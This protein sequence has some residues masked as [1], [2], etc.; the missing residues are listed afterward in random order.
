MAS[1]GISFFATPE[2]MAKWVKQLASCGE[3]KFAGEF[4]PSARVKTTALKPHYDRVAAEELSPSEFWPD[5][6]NISVDDGRPITKEQAKAPGE[7]CIILLD[8][9]RLTDGVLHMAVLGA[10]SDW[11][12]SADQVSYHNPDTIDLFNLVA[13]QLR[14]ML[15]RGV[16]GKNIKGGDGHYY[17]N[18][19]YTEAVHKLTASGKLELMQNGVANVRFYCGNAKA[20]PKQGASSKLKPKAQAKD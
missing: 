8:L 13:K 12:D 9:P 2:E 1:R 7:N 3:Y 5:R 15:I 19:S 18:I 16:T 10:K 11:W 20:Q 6:L 4:W 14:P 17:R